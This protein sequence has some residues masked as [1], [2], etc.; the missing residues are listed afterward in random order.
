MSQARLFDR[1]AGQSSTSGTLRTPA[2]A[3]M[4]SPQSHLGADPQLST[5]RDLLCNLCMG[6][7]G[8]S[9][10]ESATKAAGQLMRLRMIELI[11]IIKF[12]ADPTKVEDR[13]WG[14]E[15][16]WKK[17]TRSGGVNPRRPAE[18]VD[19]TSRDGVWVCPGLRGCRQPPGENQGPGRSMW[20]ICMEM[21]RDAEM[22]EAGDVLPDAVYLWP[23]NLREATGP[24]TLSTIV[25][26]EGVDSAASEIAPMQ[27]GKQSGA[28][29]TTASV[30]PH[31][32]LSPKNIHMIGTKFCLLVHVNHARLRLKTRHGSD[33]RTAIFDSRPGAG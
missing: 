17:G 4:H 24:V 33:V 32:H 13:G 20:L 21:R 14:Q 25:G 31:V 7:D 18:R 11:Q 10:D 9:P 6:R 15:K 30:G 3:E 5:F 29:I 2:H 19:G 26:L 27:P 12:R 22:G 1:T 16:K 8:H 28:P 23:D